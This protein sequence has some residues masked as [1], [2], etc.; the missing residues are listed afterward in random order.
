MAEKVRQ[1]LVEEARKFLLN[2]KVLTEK[3]ENK[4]AF[5]MK[6]GLTEEEINVAF[7]MV[8]KNMMMSHSASSPSFGPPVPYIPQQPSSRWSQVR[9]YANLVLILSG[10]SYGIHYIY[11]CYIGPLL[12]GHREKSVE[13]SMIE[14]QH[15]V[16]TVLKDV[17][18][19]LS[20][21]E[22]TLSAQT[23]KIQIINVENTSATD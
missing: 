6:K 11:K 16:A 21:L 17:Q 5:L 19:T 4:R 12:T 20:T 8:P 13:E 14:L 3:D 23:I 18:N 10:A 22:Q 9:D 7:S 1:D 15:S 2:P